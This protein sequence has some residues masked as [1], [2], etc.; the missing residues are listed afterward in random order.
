VPES[1]EKNEL[2][3]GLRRYDENIIMPLKNGIQVKRNN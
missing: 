1:N 2:D 3:T